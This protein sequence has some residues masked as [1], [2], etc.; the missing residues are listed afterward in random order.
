MNPV[1]LV[2]VPMPPR[3]QTPVT[4]CTAGCAGASQW[5]S[6]CLWRGGCHSWGQGEPPQPCSGRDPEGALQ[7]APW[8]W[9]PPASMATVVAAAG[10]PFVCEGQKGPGGLEA[11]A[12]DLAEQILS[13][14]PT[15]RVG[16]AN[17]C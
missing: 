16:H 7:A 2:S 1:P 17:A 12:G 4:P 11:G 9:V 5:L 6:G 3:W 10:A 8:E 13:C 15:S 14:R